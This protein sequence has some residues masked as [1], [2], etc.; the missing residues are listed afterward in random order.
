MG[1]HAKV[2]RLWPF[3]NL[4]IDRFPPML[5]NELRYRAEI[6]FI[7]FTIKRPNSTKQE[8]LVH[9]RLPFVESAGLVTIHC[10]EIIE[11][12]FKQDYKEDLSEL[13][14]Q[15]S[16]WSLGLQQN[17][18]SEL[19]KGPTVTLAKILFFCWNKN[20]TKTFQ[21]SSNIIKYTPYLFL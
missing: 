11:Q 2:R 4:K 3:K 10:E 13:A 9:H 12:D 8:W 14:K 1:L 5:E 6:C 15:T 21:L 19:H 20:L 18:I 17:F 7:L 16:Y